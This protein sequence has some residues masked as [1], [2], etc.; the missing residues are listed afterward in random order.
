[1]G[2][3]AHVSTVGLRERM[4][5]LATSKVADRPPTTE[6]VMNHLQTLHASAG[7]DA[8][9]RN[10]RFLKYVVE[11]TL[12]GGGNRIKAYNIALAVFDR[13]D[14]FDP[15]TDPIVRIEASRLRRSL[16][17]YYLTAGKQ[18][19]VRIDIPKGSYVAVFTHKTIDT[20]SSPAE[21]PQVAPDIA[22]EPPQ[23]QQ[24]SPGI[25]SQTMDTRVPPLAMLA[26]AL[27]AMIW[28]VFQVWDTAAGWSTTQARG[29]KIVVLPFED[30][31]E[32]H[33]RSFIARG[34]T[35]GIIASL[36]RF[37]DLFIY[38][39]ETSFRMDGPEPPV[40]AEYVL[41]GTVL[42]TDTEVRVFAALQD[43]VT[44]Q[45][46]W[47]WTNNGPLNPATIVSLQADVAD[48]VARA[49]AQPY[50]VVFERTA[51][52]LAGKPAKDL[53]SYECVVRFQQYW[54]VY[55]AREYD[56]LRRCMEA[57]VREDPGYARARS[58]LA[59][60]YVD[61]YRFGYGTEKL[62]FDPVQRAL[63]FAESAIDLEPRSSD[64]YLAL[65][66]ARWFDHD[67][68]G[69]LEAANYGLT[70]NPNN[71]NLIGELGIRYALLARWDES[72]AM[73]DKLYARNPR[74][75]AGYRRATFLNAYMHGDYR[76]ALAEAMASEM[77]LNL[78]DHVIRA[79]V[80][81]QL[82]DREKAKSAVSEILRLDSKYGEHV[83]EDFIKRNAHPTIVQAIAEGLTKA[84][85][86]E[87]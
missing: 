52:E 6:E 29:P 32:T 82:G 66:V 83:A 73:I 26:V 17:H 16:E 62:N 47:S 68:D 28:L 53:L 74:A 50:G 13:G 63:E 40:D 67:V 7:F 71:T 81:A 4:V 44:G 45:N 49:V 19:R 87:H 76:R 41:S 61:A 24:T 2:R 65:S 54:R 38:G 35:Y 12:A 60:L 15:L 20:A 5:Q 80:Y 48:Q 31:S 21:T 42:P 23:P 77:P 39:P 9:K 1:M 85:L 59:L 36:T 46:V 37:E 58:S 10:K 55:D 43:A 3:N 34:L 69:S 25:A 51:T 30:V 8:S 56:D 22:P 75:P 79:M 11:E 84:G 72:K 86:P 14:D 27:A 64:G 70:L 78:Y 18:D 57:T 33:A